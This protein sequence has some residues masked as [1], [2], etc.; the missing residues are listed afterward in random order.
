[1][2]VSGKVIVPRLHSALG[3]RGDINH[4]VG[5]RGARYVVAVNINKRADIFMSA[6]LGVVGETV[7]IS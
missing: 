7:E 1:V 2:G 3:I 6:D 5:I 4:L